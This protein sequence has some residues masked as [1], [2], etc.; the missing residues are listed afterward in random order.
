MPAANSEGAGESAEYRPK[1]RRV[2]NVVIGSLARGIFGVSS[3][4]VNYSAF[5]KPKGAFALAFNEK[6]DIDVWHYTNLA[7]LLGISSSRKIWA[8]SILHMN[9][10]EEYH[11]TFRLFS[12]AIKDIEEN[13]PNNL[14]VDFIKRFRREAKRQVSYYAFVACFSESR[15]QLSQWRA[16]SDDTGRFSLRFKGRFLGALSDGLNN[17]VEKLGLES[18]NYALFRLSKIVYD[19]RKKVEIIMNFLEMIEEFILNNKIDSKNDN[20]F[21]VLSEMTLAVL[22]NLAVMLKDRAFSEEKEYRLICIHENKG[23]AKSLVADSPIKFRSG[24]YGVTPY[25]EIGLDN[26]DAPTDLLPI[27][28]IMLG[29]MRY[30]GQAMQATKLLMR[31]VGLLHADLTYSAVPLR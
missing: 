19:D 16:Y 29:P 18:E 10:E 7:G 15:D 8:T 11:H 12:E 13:F 30:L 1:Y 20:A 28:E 23:V 25:I 26:H 27:E 24:A 14:F 4:H 17:R 6:C 22:V 5:D 3:A 21:Q 2:E 31:E 9:D